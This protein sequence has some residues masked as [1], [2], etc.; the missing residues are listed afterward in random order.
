MSTSAPAVAVVIV[1]AETLVDAVALE[2][3]VP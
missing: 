3:K 2:P 1:G